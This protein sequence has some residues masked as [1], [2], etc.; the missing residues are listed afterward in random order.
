MRLH[1]SAKRLSMRASQL[2]N[3]PY[4][5][6]HEHA[7]RIG[8]GAFEYEFGAL[9]DSDNLLTRTYSNFVYVSTLHFD[10]ASWFTMHSR[11][12]SFG[13]PTKGRIFAQ[14]ASRWLPNGLLTWSFERSRSPGPLKLRQNRDEAHRVARTL[15]DQKEDELRAG[16]SRRDL[17]SLLG[18][19]P[20]TRDC[21]SY[22]NGII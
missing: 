1:G 8:S 16:T 12:E 20:S 18:S 10:W 15:I 17:M 4:C 5:S 14:G 6:T 21:K 19:P 13:P 11:H 7:N 2:Y 22:T 9:E 3:I